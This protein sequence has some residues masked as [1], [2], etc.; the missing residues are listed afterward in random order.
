M[1]K[2][3]SVTNRELPVGEINIIPIVDVSFCLVIFCLVTM[4]IM[5]TAGINVLE[6]RAG[7]GAGRTTM[8]ENV[9][10][11][12]TK[13]NRLLVDNKETAPQELFRQLAL[14]LPKTKDS[15]VVLSA[16]ESAT[17]E[18]VVDILDIAKKSGAKRLVLM[19]TTGATQGQGANL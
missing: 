15:A 14:L 18:Q 11:T 8:R 16:D 1:K 5:L 12:L 13:D 6:S 4:N 2:K 7:A 9:S 3:Q 17:C 19:D 10:V